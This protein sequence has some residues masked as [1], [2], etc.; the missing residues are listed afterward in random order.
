MNQNKVQTIIIQVSSPIE[1]TIEDSKSE[2]FRLKEHKVELQNK[3][4]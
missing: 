3:T 1:I 4:T 2:T